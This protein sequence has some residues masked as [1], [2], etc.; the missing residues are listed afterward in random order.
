MEVTCSGI[1]SGFQ[2]YQSGKA[3]RVGGKREIEKRNRNKQKV[4]EVMRQDLLRIIFKGAFRKGKASFQTT[5]Y[6]RARIDLLG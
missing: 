3:F 5:E 2:R 6:I 4:I 1:C